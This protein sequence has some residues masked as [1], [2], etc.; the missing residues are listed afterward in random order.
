M[1]S[2]TETYETWKQCLSRNMGSELNKSYV[3]ER[4]RI[5]SDPAH[6]ETKKFMQLY[7]E[8]RTSQV[9]QWFRALNLEM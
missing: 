2:M 4:V 9:L 3:Q 6:A 1:V 7:G 8:Q 5:F